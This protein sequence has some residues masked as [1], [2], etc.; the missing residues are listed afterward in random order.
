MKFKS[1]F[2]SKK[3]SLTGRLRV[4]IYKKIMDNIENKQGNLMF[5]QGRAGTG[6]TF[7]TNQ[8]IKSLKEINKKIVICGTT[9]IAASSYEGGCTV[10][11]I[12]AL[13]IA[14]QESKISF[15]SNIGFRSY[16]SKALME[17]GL[18]IKILKSQ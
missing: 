3:S 15:R 18:Y 1:S 12:F 11:S 6:K 9:G 8:I 5:I 17:S 10:H 13:G 16:R 4:Y 2:F 14:Q 7:L